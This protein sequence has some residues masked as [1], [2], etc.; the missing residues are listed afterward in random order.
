MYMRLQKH[1]WPTQ[2]IWRERAAVADYNTIFWAV[3][4][5]AVDILHLNRIK[6]FLLK[7]ALAKH[8]EQHT[9]RECLKHHSEKEKKAI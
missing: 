1:K 7:Y 5:N 3:G 2:S 9:D 4:V 8:F 6:D